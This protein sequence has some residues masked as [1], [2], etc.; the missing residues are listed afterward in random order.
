MN[1]DSQ[2]VY[3]STEVSLES[4][5]EP[6]N[7]TIGILLAGI[8]AGIV[9]TAFA[10]SSYWS[11]PDWKGER[12]E[13][14]SSIVRNLGLVIVGFPALWLAWNRTRTATRQADISNEQARIANKQAELAEKGHIT[15]RYQD[16]A[17]M[18]ESTEL[19]IRVAG[20][21]TLREVA[22]T[23]PSQT[24]F[25]VLDL[26]Y[27]FVTAKSQHR[28]AKLQFHPK[29][30]SYIDYGDFPTDLHVALISASQIRER[31]TEIG[32]EGQRS[33][34]A[35]LAG[36]N[37]SG[38][39]LDRTNLSRANLTR[40]NLSMAELRYANLSKADLKFA[41][42]KGASL[43]GTNFSGANLHRAKM[44]IS[45]VNDTNFTDAQ[46]DGA[47]LSGSTLNNANFTNASVVNADL[48]KTYAKGSNLSGGNFKD[49]N[50]ENIIKLNESWYYEDKPP[51]NIPDKVL[52]LVAIRTRI[53]S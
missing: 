45:T 13:Q 12:W 33:W 40:A 22:L 24:Y 23:N 19:S 3:S 52:N 6:A 39:D 44:N 21:Y 2:K 48:S 1:E 29:G 38:A 37:L 30:Q 41:T 53:D 28:S 46:L 51:T 43:I 42:I 49:A 31:G 27:A 25:L 35:N 5:K 4:Q 14:F 34:T 36:A 16:G 32:C 7:Q 47:N 17:R 10:L 11:L 15:S 26:L 8:L 20:I 18:L 50:F 9:I